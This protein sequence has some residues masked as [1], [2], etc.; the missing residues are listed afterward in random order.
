MGGVSLELSPDGLF[1]LA[2]ILGVVHWICILPS[3]VCFILAL[4]IQI[5]I[6]DKVAFV[7]DY[8][9]AVLPGFLVFTGFTGFIVHIAS[10]KISY[11]TRIVKKRPKWTPYLKPV[12]IATLVVFLAEFITGI[13]C[14]AHISSL[15]DGFD[16]GVRKAMAAYK[17]DATTKEKVDTLQFTFSC[18]GS[19][20]FRDWFTIT[21]VHPD[22]EGDDSRYN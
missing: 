9:E 16:R 12:V 13:V 21:W 7:E 10:G 14:F 19:R 1:K 3:F 2:K 6:Q 4:V 22:F 5:T 20:S 11:T 17:D 15:E 18:C 8:N